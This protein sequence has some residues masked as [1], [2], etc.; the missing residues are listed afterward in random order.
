MKT[1]YNPFEPS[2]KGNT[3]PH[4]VHFTSCYT[5]H[6]LGGTFYILREN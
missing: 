3:T 2:I 4:I 1:Y 5:L 6:I